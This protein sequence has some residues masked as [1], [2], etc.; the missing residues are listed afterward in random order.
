[1]L[2]SP[3]PLLLQW[4]AYVQ[5]GR[6][7]GIAYLKEA[8]SSNNMTYLVTLETL[9]WCQAAGFVE[10][11][12]ELITPGLISKLLQL[13]KRLQSSIIAANLLQLIQPVFV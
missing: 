2:F 7:K 8:L 1:V 6:K 9:T 12:D 4:L 5:H 10:Q 11:L 13:D 3:F